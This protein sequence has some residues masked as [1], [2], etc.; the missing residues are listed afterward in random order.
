[1]PAKPDFDDEGYLM[2][3]VKLEA[4]KMYSGVQKFRHSSTSISVYQT[5]Q[6]LRSNC[7]F[8][9]LVLGVQDSGFPTSSSSPFLACLLGVE[10]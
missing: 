6:D 3:V 5:Y 10:W 4:I 7:R 2:Q 9:K 8:L 1:M